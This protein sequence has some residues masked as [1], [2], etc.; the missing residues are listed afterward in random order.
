MPIDVTFT[1]ERITCVR[2][3]DGSGHSE[4][5]IWPLL[6]K[7]D[8]TTLPTPLHVA[9]IAPA[10]E[11]ARVVL[12][13]GM[14]PGDSVAIPASV[15]VLRAQFQDGLS[16]RA[17]S[18][19]VNLMEWDNTPQDAIKSGYQTFV[20]ET[21]REVGENI[22]GLAN[23]D[24]NVVQQL[25]REIAARVSAK[26]RAAIQA[27]QNWWQLLWKNQDD[28]LATNSLT[29]RN[30][31]FT[32]QTFTLAFLNPETGIVADNYVIE[33]RIVVTPVVVSHSCQAELDAVNAALAQVEAIEL[34]IAD[35]QAELQTAPGPQKPGILAEIRRIQ[36][37]EMP[38]ARAELEAARRALLECTGGSAGAS[39]TG[40]VD[41]GSVT[42]HP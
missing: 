29:L 14:K 16:Q 27:A 6:L 37:E 3:Q 24:N 11:H 35:L 22:L 5:Y 41:G 23:P 42:I 7:I 40:L 32:S 34:Q 30:F 25:K 26:V 39:S 21:S 15:G 33:G 28:F 20:S 18:L 9:P 2:E 12:Q 17:L 8:D 36:N 13:N 19:I 10:V 38:A 31:N 1:L 4:P